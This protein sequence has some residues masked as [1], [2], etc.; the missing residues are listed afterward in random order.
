[1]RWFA[2]RLYGHFDNDTTKPFWMLKY[3]FNK[4]T[5]YTVWQITKRDEKGKVDKDFCFQVANFGQNQHE[6]ESYRDYKNSIAYT[7]WSRSR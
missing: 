1:M 5:Y 3:D 2:P 4:A 6:A 7:D